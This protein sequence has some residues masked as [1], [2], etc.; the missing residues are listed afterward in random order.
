MPVNHDTAGNHAPVSLPCGHI[1]AKDC[2]SEWFKKNHPDCPLCRRRLYTKNKSL[3]I[4]AYS[5]R[6]ELPRPLKHVGES[7]T[8]VFNW[9][10]ELAP[11]ID[12]HLLAALRS[13]IRL[14]LG[15]F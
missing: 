3:P 7:W 6:Y 4:I 9:L 12:E 14:T 13:T 1:L 10:Q 11:D 15:N 8:K 2:I 5:T